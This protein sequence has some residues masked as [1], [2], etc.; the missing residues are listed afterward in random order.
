[1]VI[2]RDFE[3]NPNEPSFVFDHLS[4][5]W[6][7]TRC[8]KFSLAALL[9][10]AKPE[11]AIEV[12]TYKGGSLQVMAKHASKVYSLDI[13][14]EC[15]VELG[16][17]FEN[18][19]F[20]TGNSNLLLPDLLKTISQSAEHLGFVLIDGDHST[21]AVRN[22]VNAVLDYAPVRPLFLVCHDSF[23]PECRKGILQ[24]DW[25]RNPHVHYVEIDF[26]PGVF[27]QEAFDTAESR[28][29][30]GGLCVALMLPQQRDH[31][32]AIHQ[33]QKGLYDAVYA[34]SRYS[35]PLRKA[36]NSLK[37]MKSQFS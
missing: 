36:K 16:P 14:P 1:M 21:D 11:I 25:A 31:S 27:H 2:Q 29:M 23:H 5:D 3:S 12:G 34:R 10:H 15:A 30:F 13:S 37:A 33:S 8:E 32:I 17:H 28:S 4:F 20:L 22:D 7:M 24:A 18:V 6:Q 9:E 26:V 19:K 35:S